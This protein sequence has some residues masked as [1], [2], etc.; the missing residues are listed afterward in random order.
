[1]RVDVHT[2]FL[3]PELF[4]LMAEHGAER[5]VDS[6][7]VFGTMLRG[8]SERLFAAGPEAVIE[9][10]TT[11]LDDAGFDLAVISLGA[12]QPYFP[13]SSTGT[14]VARRANL[15]LHEAVRNA[16]GRL[17]A[18]G[19]L[20]LPH[21]DASL[22]ELRF[23][24][25]ECGFAGVNLGT[26]ACG[27]P[28]DA[29]ELDDLWALLDERRATVFIHPGTTP[30]MGVGSTDFHL[31]PDFCSP[32]ETALALCR[33]VVGGVTTRHPDV[34]I[35][36][37]AMGGSLPFFAHRFDTGMRRSHPALYEELG[38]VLPHLRR[39]WYDT[40]MIEE[41]RVFDSVRHSLGVDR[42]VFGSD[43][44]RGPLADV[45]D[46]VMSSPQ[47]V[48]AEKAHIL[49][50]GGADA[51]GRPRATTAPDPFSPVGAPT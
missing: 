35:V 31:A 7:K 2:H 34:R 15:M 11:Q 16:G 37:A 48:D 26:S 10:W 33:L 9:D 40:S 32:T 3:P 38:G 50:V 18:F 14:T 21:L 45:V 20:P 8:G 1:M 25:D 51:L 12:L 4:D 29:P 41:P 47:L 17:A 49:D 39:F 42:L 5:T 46:F 44:P 13:Q 43:L 28:L 36:A 6:F 27:H 19:S 30:L 23:C 22:A 24:L